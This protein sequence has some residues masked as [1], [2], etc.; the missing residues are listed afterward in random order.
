LLELTSN[1][2]VFS[3]VDWDKGK[4]WADGLSWERVKGYN[5]RWNEK[6]L[7][8]SLVYEYIPGVDNIQNVGDHY[9]M[10]LSMRL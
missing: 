2:L 1:N 9:Y 8:I 7:S 5:S 10:N 3:L 6:S 4:T